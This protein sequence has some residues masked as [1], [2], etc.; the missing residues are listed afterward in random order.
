MNFKSFFFFFSVYF[1][2]FPSCSTT[3][4]LF[5]QV[6]TTTT[7]QMSADIPLVPKRPPKLALRLN[8]TSTATSSS[9]DNNSLSS[10]STSTTSIN[11]NTIPIISTSTT[12]TT[13]SISTRPKLKLNSISIPLSKLSLSIPS[14]YSTSLNQPTDEGNPSSSSS[15]E[16]DSEESHK[17][18]KGDQARM[19]FEIKE[20]IE[21]PVGLEEDLAGKGNGCGGLRIERRVRSN[22]R[23]SMVRPGT[24]GS[25]GNSESESV[26]I[27]G[28]NKEEQTS[29]GPS[30]LRK[31]DSINATEEDVGILQNELIVNPS[32]LL[33]LGRLGE[34]ASGEVRKV[35]HL[36]TGIIMAKKVSRETSSTIFDSNY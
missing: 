17:W 19:A 33:D 23:V 12:S 31:E 6:V 11:S 25:S 4:L 36:P 13:S 22:S 14:H 24:G 28:N 35:K 29:L 20:I 8:V 16:S 9:S 5:L 7:Y 3:S 21:R 26:N 10:A 27:V 18:K 1:F 32:T 15:S 34:G 2:W 30:G